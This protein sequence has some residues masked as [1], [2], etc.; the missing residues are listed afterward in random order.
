[1]GITTTT[2]HLTT[3]TT[4]IHPM[5]TMIMTTSLDAKSPSG[6]IPAQKVAAS[7]T[8]LD[9]PITGKSRTPGASAMAMLASS[10]FR[11]PTARVSA[12]LTA[13]STGP[14]GVQTNTE[15]TACIL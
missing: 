6:G 14:T 7:R 9:T 15:L 10:E 5:I 3:T 12:V 13:K 11:S 1:M 8:L 4:T 2:I